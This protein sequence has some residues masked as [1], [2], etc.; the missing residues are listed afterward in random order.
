[1]FLRVLDFV[2]MKKSKESKKR[3]KVNEKDE[4]QMDEDQMNEDPDL[5]EEPHKQHGTPQSWCEVWS[6]A[7]HHDRWTHIN[8]LQ[9]QIDK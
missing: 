7:R 2:H 3:L 1:M 8:P 9:S 4:D 5:P 6:E